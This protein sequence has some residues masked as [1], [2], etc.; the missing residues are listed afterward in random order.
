M[1]AIGSRPCWGRAGGTAGGQYGAG[2]W[3]KASRLRRQ[4]LLRDRTRGCQEDPYPWPESAE[5]R[6]NGTG[7]SWGPCRL[8]FMVIGHFY[9]WES[10]GLEREGTSTNMLV[11]GVSVPM[12]Q[13][14]GTG[15]SWNHLAQG[16]LV[17]FPGFCFHGLRL[18]CFHFFLLC[19][20]VWNST[21]WFK[22][23]SSF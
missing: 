15:T 11:G 10:G 12:R 20:L 4:A 14:G 5:R 19:K 21:C 9:R 13:R 8:I 17:C 6:K 3:R 1:A 7:S 18:A 22:T 2:L 16:H 23:Q